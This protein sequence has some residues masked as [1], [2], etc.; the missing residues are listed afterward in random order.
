MKIKHLAL[1]L[2]IAAAVAGCAAHYTLVPPAI[3]LTSLGSVGLVMFTAK[4]AKGD[5]DAAA[6]QSFLEEITAAQRVP[7]VELGRADKVLADVEKSDFDR[8]AVLA[9]GRKQGVDALF[10][11]EIAVTRIKPQLDLAAPLS[12]ALFAR[13][14][15]DMTARVRLISTKNGATLWTNSAVRQATVGSI[16]I[17][18]GVPVFA[19]RDKNAALNDLLRQIMW[20]LTWDFRPSR[21]RVR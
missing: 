12:R 14:A 1:A 19:V 16:G 11:G 18:D 17:E 20:Q 8:D 7:V 4:D 5:L 15:M 13:A 21:Q 2:F 3:D 10:V 9:V 6:T